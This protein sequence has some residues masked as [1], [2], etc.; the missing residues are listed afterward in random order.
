MRIRSSPAREDIYPQIFLDVG[1]FCKF[2]MET[3]FYY[4]P[5]YTIPTSADPSGFCLLVRT[6]HEGM[7]VTVNLFFKA[8][9]NKQSC[10]V[11][12]IRIILGTKTIAS[13]FLNEFVLQHHIKFNKNIILIEAR[14]Q[15]AVRVGDHRKIERMCF[16]VHF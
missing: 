5:F 2:L 12:Y 15:F 13:L 10:S 9:C 3:S 1:R 4:K 7:N 14:A 11:K 6:D 8:S 16:F